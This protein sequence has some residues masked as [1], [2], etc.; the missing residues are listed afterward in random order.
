[1]FSLE[2]IKLKLAFQP[3][4]NES[5][6]SLKE[7]FL[8]IMSSRE[9]DKSFKR[10]LTRMSSLERIKLKL[11]FQTFLNESRKSLK[12]AFLPIMFSR[13]K[14]KSFKRSLT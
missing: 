3:Y 14:D 2:R 7:A 12:K 9:K 6:K 4:L 13:E 5:R 1:M 11:A 8:P 10:S